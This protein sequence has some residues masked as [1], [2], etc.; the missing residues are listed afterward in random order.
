MLVSAI[1]QHES[2]I[3]IYIRL[4]PP[5]PSL[6]PHPTPLGCHR[7]LVWA[8]CAI[9]QIPAGWLCY[10]CWC[11]YVSATLSIRPTLSFPDCVH[12]S[13]LN[14]LQLCLHSMPWFCGCEA[15]GTLTPQPGIK[16]VPPALEGEVLTTG[17]PGKSCAGIS[18]PVPVPYLCGS[19]PVLPWSSLG[20]N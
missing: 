13:S 20:W 5:E 8:A 17:P 4:L 12:K 11:I 10:A 3:S 6:P 18:L 1:H 14:L 2:A 9:Q 7:A 15:R 19:V 16:S